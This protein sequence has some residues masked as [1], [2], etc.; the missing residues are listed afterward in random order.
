MLKA[1]T[2]YDPW[3]SLMSKRER[4]FGNYDEGRYFYRCRNVRRLNKPIPTRGYQAIGWTVPPEIEDLVREQVPK[5]WESQIMG[6]PHEQCIKN[7]CRSEGH[8]NCPSCVMDRR[9]NHD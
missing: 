7:E 2:L 8:C 1:I 3:G 9:F 5:V 6:V 4:V